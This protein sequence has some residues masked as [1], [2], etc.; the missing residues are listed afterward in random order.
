MPFDEQREVYARVMVTLSERHYIFLNTLFSLSEACLYAQLVDLLDAQELPRVLGYEDIYRWVRDSIDQAHVEGQLKAEIVAHPERFVVQDND[1]AMAL[2]DQ[3][4]AGKKL[5]LITNSDWHYTRAM[6][7][8]VFDRCSAQVHDLARL[9][10]LRHGRR[11]QARVFYATGAGVR[12]GR[13]RRPAAPQRATRMQEGGVYWGGDAALV[14]ETLSLSGDEILYVGDHIYGDVNVSK[15]R[16]CAGAQDLILRELEADL[17][18][19]EAFAPHQERLNALMTTKEQLETQISQLRLQL[20]RKKSAYGPAL[21]I[22]NAWLQDA[23]SQVR[24][25]VLASG[26]R[27]QTFGPGRSPAEQF[28]L[29]PHHARRQRQ[30]SLGKAGGATRRYLHVACLQLPLPNALCLSALV[31]RESCRMTQQTTS[32]TTKA[33]A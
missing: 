20:M 30:E 22:N 6:M 21:E 10:Q 2:L 14:E 3:V 19:F 18:A 27:D 26:R 33:N 8:Y 12:G 7:A 29:G 24:S 28:L 11:P 13:R 9:V 17:A 16:C 1:C 25:E 23:I 31:A 32:A 5:L 4:H 15:T